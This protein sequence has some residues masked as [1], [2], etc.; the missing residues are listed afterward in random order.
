MLPEER[1]I[2][3]QERVHPDQMEVIVPADDGSK[4]YKKVGVLAALYPQEDHSST[5]PPGERLCVIL[6]GNHVTE[7]ECVM[8]RLR[9]S[10]SSSLI[11]AHPH[12]RLMNETGYEE[13][14]H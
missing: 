13:F 7:G 6:Q 3:A 8:I 5:C 14:H 2:C 11:F 1:V 12:T 4:Q 10:A 9:R